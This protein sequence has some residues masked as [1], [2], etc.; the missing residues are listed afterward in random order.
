METLNAQKNKLEKETS[1]PPGTSSSTQ[2]SFKIIKNYFDQQKSQTVE[3]KIQTLDV[4]LN[5]IIS[6]FNQIKNHDEKGPKTS[7]ASESK[8]NVDQSKPK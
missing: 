5:S 2:K 3:E 1:P 8:S 6:L 4:K 7:G